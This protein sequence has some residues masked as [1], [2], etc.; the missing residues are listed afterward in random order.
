[1][2]IASKFYRISIPNPPFFL[3]IYFLGGGGA[4]PAAHGSSQARDQIRHL[5]AYTTAQQHRIQAT[6]VNY[7]TAH[8]STGSLTH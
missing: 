3:F 6:S 1:M 5:L 2:I 8:D 4:A 7:T